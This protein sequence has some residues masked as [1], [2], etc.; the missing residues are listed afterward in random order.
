MF[1]RAEQFGFGR[2]IGRFYGLLT[3]ARPATR[4]RAAIP[5][6][7]EYLDAAELA[8]RYSAAQISRL[9]TQGKLVNLANAMGTFFTWNLPALRNPPRGPF[10]IK[11]VYEMRDVFAN[12]NN[13]SIAILNEVF[14]ATGR[15]FTKL[16]AKVNADMIM[17]LRNHFDPGTGALMRPPI[18]NMARPEQ[19]NNFRVQALIVFNQ[20]DPTSVMA[21][22]RVRAQ[23]TAALRTARVYPRDFA[24]TFHHI[25]RSRIAH[26][27]GFQ[28]S[29]IEL[30]MFRSR[31]NQPL[32]GSKKTVEKLLKNTVKM[33]MAKK[34]RSETQEFLESL[35]IDEKTII[36]PKTR[37]N[38][39]MSAAII[40][41]SSKIGKRSMNTLAAR[42]YNFIIEEKGL[43]TRERF[44]EELTMEEV[45]QWVSNRRNVELVVYDHRGTT[46]HSIKP[47]IKRARKRKLPRGEMVLLGNHLC[48]IVKTAL[49]KREAAKSITLA[50]EPEFGIIT[51]YIPRNCRPSKRVVK[52]I[53]GVWDTETLFEEEMRAYAIGLYLGDEEPTFFYGPNCVKEFVTQ[54]FI[55]GG[56]AKRK[57]QNWELTLWAHNGGKFDMFLVLEELAKHKNS[58]FENITVVGGSIIYLKYIIYLDKSKFV[59][60]FKDSYH[61]LKCSLRKAAQLFQTPIQKGELN[62]RALDTWESAE[63]HK[64][65]VI[66]YLNADLISLYQVLQKYDRYTRAEFSHSV[67]NSSTISTYSMKTFRYVLGEFYDI[68]RTPLFSVKGELDTFIRESFFGGCVE[69][70]QRGEIK[71]EASYMDFTSL[72]PFVM[73]KFPI[74]I[75]APVVISDEDSSEEKILSGEWFGFVSVTVQGGYRDRPNLIPYRKDTGHVVFPYFETPTT[76]VLPTEMIILVYAH[77]LPYRFTDY[78]RG[79]SFQRGYPFSKYIKMLFQKRLLA[80][81]A[82]NEVLSLLFK[83][84]MNAFFGTFGFKPIRTNYAIHDNDKPIRDLFM[85]N[86]LK[87][88]NTIGEKYMVMYEDVVER[89]TNAIHI[90]S[91]I[92]F[93]ARWVLYE[94]KQH[95]LENGFDV[96]YTDTDSL[97]T[98]AKLG[99]MLEKLPRKYFYDEEGRYTAG[100]HL[101]GLKVEKS[102]KGMI[103]LGLKTYMI[104][105]LLT[106]RGFSQKMRFKEKIIDITTNTIEMI[107]QGEGE[108]RI[109]K[110][111]MRLLAEGYRLKQEVDQI[112]TSLAAFMDPRGKRKPMEIKKKEIVFD[113]TEYKKGDIRIDGRVYPMVI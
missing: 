68:T 67:L 109:T 43:E 60:C 44:D 113:F 91:Y 1:T 106:M 40:A 31:Y 76:M 42:Y 111:D 13:E 52:E 69:M 36:V 89:P 99:D 112:H 110:E 101:G 59:V 21:P 39:M 71:E 5:F 22:T 50:S 75:G 82:K 51:H 30:I 29:S 15:G 87:E 83:L 61:I 20:Y 62:Y 4:A 26:Y 27:Y 34:Y 9:R 72:Y 38:C 74:P 92:T 17:L 32:S 28:L 80:K 95:F 12:L 49:S 64:R 19:S 85:C 54:L 78:G 90:A 46:L 63:K 10:L 11:G 108:E 33:E 84:M 73:T 6:D 25:L 86:G 88:F 45:L 14:Q 104:G 24:E 16:V 41:I 35:E 47:T 70:W 103:I 79:V 18:L 48:A 65:E 77:R 56:E 107:G 98:T 105:D 2:R 96:L 37:V 8:N 81:A 97:V 93:W 57:R 55:I 23:R 7:M 102:G 53:S 3:A 100:N 66:K 58:S 94:A